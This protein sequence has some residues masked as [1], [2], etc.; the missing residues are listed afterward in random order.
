MIRPEVPSEPARVWNVPE[1]ARSFPD[2]AHR[3]I[4]VEREIKRKKIRIVLY[5]PNERV[6]RGRGH[7]Y[8]EIERQVESR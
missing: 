1:K 5:V 4:I 7:Q 8:G 3:G 2:H 6:D